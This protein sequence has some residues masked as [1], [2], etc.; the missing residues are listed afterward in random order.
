MQTH[1]RLT[2][3]FGALL[4][5]GVVLYSC[6][7]DFLE[8]APTGSLNEAV[9]S[10]PAGIDGL[11]IGAYS[12]LGGR[13]NWFGGASNWVHGSI[14]GG[15]ANKGTE[16]GDFTAI[17]EVVEYQ[18]S[19]TSQVPANRWTGIFE[20]V[21]R[22]N[23]AIKVASQSEDPTV[24]EALRTRAVAEGR[25]LRGHYYFQLEITFNQAPY[26][27]E[28]MTSE[29]VVT[30]PSTDLW[31]HIE[32]DFRFAYDN[33]P[34]TQSQAGRANKTAAAA[35]L[36]KTYLFQGKWAEAKQ[37][38]DWVVANG[39]TANGQEVGLMESYSEVFNAEFDNN[40]ESLFAIQAA[41]NTGTTN[42][43]N[44]DFALNFP[45]N[46]G[47]SGPGNCCGFF[48][49]SF[50]LV[51]SFRTEDGLP[52][53]DEQY[54]QDQYEVA[55][56]FGLASAEPFTPDSGPLDPRL[57]HSV[58]RRGIPYLDWG[59]FPGRDWI[60]DQPHAG[61][62]SPKKFVYYQSQENTFSDGTSWTR[63]YPA[64]NYVVIRYADVL[65]MLAEA[66]IELN[67]LSRALE[68]INMV[69]E[70]AQNSELTTDDGSPAANYE[71]ALYDD[72]GSQDNA[73]KIL[74]F[75]RKLELSGEGHRF[76]DLRRWG[77]AES[78]LNGYIN[79]EK[80]FLPVQFGGAQFTAPQDLYYPIPQG[81]IDLQGFEVLGQNPGYN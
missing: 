30:T 45:H 4:S 73:R 49:P 6:S 64:V 41:A 35:Y 1:K 10:S 68:L 36:G 17:N 51:N 75:E 58:G 81:Q 53:L 40:K 80:Q 72:L 44:P 7:E 71:I 2:Y 32:E 47:S 27:T 78:F 34:E 18:L 54:R 43:A 76:F 69:R 8:V 15:D 12:Q 77:K 56:D 65:L 23:A 38:F 63:G 22:S 67:N 37:M 57:D 14:Q 42:N 24:T 9:L 11:L 74:Q 19:P 29:E 3:I 79:Y 48:Q 26:I 5:M 21:A 20:G 28:L 55:N 50:D 60:R 62:Y 59:L 66:E 46:T 31:P 13:G 61:P 39:M 33:L 16:T 25:F 70:R 52:L